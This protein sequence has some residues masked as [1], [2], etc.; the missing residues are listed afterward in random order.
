MTGPDGYTGTCSVGGPPAVR[1]IPGLRVTKVAVGG[2]DNNCYLLRCAATGSTLVIDAPAPC[3]AIVDAVGDGTPVAIV[4]THGH[5]DHVAGLSELAERLGVPVRCHPADADLLPVPPASTVT[6]GDSI[7]FGAAAVRVVHL[8]GHTPG[9][10]ALV[11]DAAGQLSASPHVFAGDC[12]FPGGPGATGGDPL[13]FAML[14]GDLEEKLFWPLPDL[15]WIYPGHGR[16]TTL[17]AE[18]PHLG[19]WRA[20]GW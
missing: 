6:D 9:S 20:R 18:R 1:T 5:S 4:V 17:G 14:L 3:A 8:R 7:D 15:T 2:M 11:Y 10:I 16:D 19:A 13:R 12:L